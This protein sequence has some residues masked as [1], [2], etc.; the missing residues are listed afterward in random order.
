MDCLEFPLGGVS[1][2]ATLDCDHTISDFADATQWQSNIDA[3]L[4]KIYKNVKG[5][6]PAASP[7]QV[8]RPIGC[9]A[10]QLII[11]FDNTMNVKDSNV[12]ENNDDLYAKLNRQE[13]IMVAFMCEQNQIRVGAQAATF[14]AVP[15]MVPEGNR[16]LQMYQIGGIFFTKPTEVPFA[17]YDAPEG[18]FTD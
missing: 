10:A 18:I 3:G 9:G 15:A 6:I 13:L 8:D 16:V 4:A 2:F 14:T 17:L 7:I 1:A 5:E 12:N 11:G